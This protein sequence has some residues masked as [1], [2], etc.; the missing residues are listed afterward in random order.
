[1]L[2]HEY[3]CHHVPIYTAPEAYIVIGRTD[4]EQIYVAESITTDAERFGYVVR[5]QRSNKPLRHP[6]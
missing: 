2:F 1:M 4:R 3:V 5:S 6:I